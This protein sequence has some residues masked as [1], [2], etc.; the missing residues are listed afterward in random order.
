[1]APINLYDA[2]IALFIRG[3]IS[4]IDVLKKASE[5]PNADA[6]PAARLAE[7]M[8]PLIKQI[9]FISDTA[10]RT[11]ERLTGTEVGVWEDN[12]KTLPELIARAEKTLELLKTV[13][14]KAVEGVEDTVVPMQMGPNKMELPA[15][16][17]VLGF[18]VPNIFFHFGMAYAIL[19]SNGIPLGKRDYLGPFFNPL[20]PETQ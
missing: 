4:L 9:H 15:I 18:A 1:M 10:K 2:S 19:R 8:L 12:E 13:D 16:S 17:Y 11:V 3:H 20:K 5:A 14:P 7:D 6:L